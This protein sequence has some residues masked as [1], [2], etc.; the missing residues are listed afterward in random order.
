MNE[1]LYVSELLNQIYLQL[2]KC[3]ENCR[4]IEYLF[5]KNVMSKMMTVMICIS[6]SIVFLM[7]RNSLVDM[8]R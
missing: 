4:D 7:Q 2:S 8:I 5:E 6:D 1:K 3:L